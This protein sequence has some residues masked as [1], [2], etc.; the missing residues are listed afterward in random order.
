[1]KLSIVPIYVLLV[2]S[3]SVYITYR[4][5]RD[6]SVSM[7]EARSV[8]LFITG[9]IGWTV[10]ATVLGLR[11]IHTAP[12]L[13]DRVPILW[14]AC[15]AVSMFMGMFALSHT[16]RR[17]L[18]GL[19][20]ATPTTW[21]VFFQALRIGAIG[22][23]VKAVRGEITSSFPLWVGIP[24]F[25][26][27]VSSIFLGWL[28]LRGSVGHPTTLVIWALAGAGIILLPLFGLMP[29]WMNEPGFSFI[30]EFPMVMS[31]SI[32]VPILILFDF[33]LA[34]KA[35]RQGSAE[36]RGNRLAGSPLSVG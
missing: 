22:T 1:M 17:A 25:L 21:L 18:D 8:Y 11:D 27:G 23:V 36:L 15:V 30:F 9:L 5:R 6:D 10:V 35:I 14:Q 29:Y 3:F 32:I 20:D 4:A 31:P 7:P 28:L 13:L 24:D 16:F 2:F 19:A 34:W 26:Y 33:L 12:W